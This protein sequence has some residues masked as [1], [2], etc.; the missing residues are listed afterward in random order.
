M[1][2]TCEPLRGVFCEV[3]MLMSRFVVRSEPLGVALDAVS[4]LAVQ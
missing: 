3:L 2:N 1:N 4:V